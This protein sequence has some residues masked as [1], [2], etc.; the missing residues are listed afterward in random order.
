MVLKISRHLLYTHIQ[1][2]RNITYPNEKQEAETLYF[3]CFVKR[4]KGIVGVGPLPLN[5]IKMFIDI[6]SWSIT[7]TK[8]PIKS[9]L[10][11]WKKHPSP[12]PFM[13]LNLFDLYFMLFLPS[14]SDI[15][16]SSKANTIYGIQ[17]KLL[18]HI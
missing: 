15:R 11:V 2:N 14:L 16:C 1:C 18:L 12:V 8:N 6:P 3:C 10:N 7:H 9:S 4:A 17:F 13:S 5:P